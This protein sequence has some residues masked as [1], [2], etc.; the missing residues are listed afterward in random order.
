MRPRAAPACNTE[1]RTGKEGRITRQLGGHG[2]RRAH[3]V[4]P[5]GM[6][7][8]P[9]PAFCLASFFFS[10]ITACSMRGGWGGYY[11]TN[12]WEE[13]AAARRILPCARMAQPA[14]PPQH[15]AFPPRRHGASRI[16]ER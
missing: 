14:H 4:R 9:I 15:A 8:L 2:R 16:A 6:P 12:G 10:V 13:G 3:M 11:W 5:A 1:R 7:A